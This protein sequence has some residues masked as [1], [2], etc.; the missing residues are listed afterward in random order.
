MAGRIS[1]L[2][3]EDSVDDVAVLRR[4]IRRLPGNYLVDIAYTGQEALAKTR[5]QA[6]DVA[7][8]DQHLPDVAGND[9]IRDLRAEHAH[10]PVVMLTGHGDERLAVEVMKAG[11]YDYM[12]KDD[13]DAQALER[14]LRNVLERAR[15]EAEVR[16]ANER[17][18]EWA[19]RDG[20]TGLYNHRHFQEQLLTEFARAR[21]YAQPLACL[22]ID[23]DHFKR[24]NDTCG[25]PFGDEVL[26]QLAR[27]LTEVARQAD[28]IARYGGEEFVVVLPSTDLEGARRFAERVRAEVAARPVQADGQSVDITLSVGVA[29]NGTP[30]VDSERALIKRADAALYE[31]K[32]AGRNRVCVADDQEALPDLQTPPPTERLTTSELRV[33]VVEGMLAVARMVEQADDGR[34]DHGRRVADLAVACGRRL[35]VERRDLEALRLG[36]MLHDLGRLA[37]RREAEGGRDPA[38][39]AQHT[40]RGAEVLATFGLFDAEID[41]VR[42]HHERWDGQ[43]CPDGL[44]GEAIPLLARIVSVADAFDVLT[45]CRAG[46]EGLERAEALTAMTADAGTRYDPRVVEALREVVGDR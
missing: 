21:R 6:F 2:L 44:R 18:R 22:M 10:L 37:V 32:R 29:T 26:K 9:L 30:G 31:A 15:L 36:A 42:H 35:G 8:V 34:R 7:L 43:G 39:L 5:S 23:L 19:I 4:Y 16:R 12:R 25:H 27:T 46:R 13:L 40:Q 38:A 45:T 41:V 17:L 33:R 3:V 11:A 14:T 20:L 28:I 1:I 24:I